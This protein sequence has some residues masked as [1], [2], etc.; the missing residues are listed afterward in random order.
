M[1]AEKA[2]ERR[3]RMTVAVD[4]AFATAAVNNRLRAD[5]PILGLQELAN[6]ILTRVHCEGMSALQLR[7]RTEDAVYSDAQ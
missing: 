7:R 4:R 6:L 5:L 1:P 3:G 2:M